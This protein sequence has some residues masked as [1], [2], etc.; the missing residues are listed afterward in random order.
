[1]ASKAS[2]Q[3]LDL[4]Q[5]HPVMNGIVVREISSLILRPATA[6]ASSGPSG[7]SVGK[8]NHHARY[9][10]VLTI[11]QTMLTARD[12]DVATRLV[13]LYFELFESVLHEAER[14]G[15]KDEVQKAGEDGK[16][17]E[18]SKK[19][20]KARWRDS[21]G[22]KGKGKGKGKGAAQPEGHAKAVQDAEGKMMAAILAGVRRAFPFATIDDDV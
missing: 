12:T 13:S 21:K 18:N 1:M 5:A 10:G 6:V 4:L 9:Y 8:H 17:D 2:T 11:N 15:A 19:P 20:K 16:E 14:G 22:S 3:L 7:G